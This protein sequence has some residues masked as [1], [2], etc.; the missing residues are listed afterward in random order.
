SP[1]MSRRCYYW[2]SRSPDARASARRAQSWILHRNPGRLRL[3]GRILS[4]LFSGRASPQPNRVMQLRPYQSDCVQAVEAGW[5]EASK[6]LIVVPTGG[7]KT[8]LFASLAAR[9]TGRTLILA[10]REELIGQAVEKIRAATGLEAD[11]EKAERYANRD[12]KV[13]VAS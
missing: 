13:V 7:G 11:I 6:Q 8:I 4:S 12:A 5:S 3:S 9:R 1:S 2:R 10:H